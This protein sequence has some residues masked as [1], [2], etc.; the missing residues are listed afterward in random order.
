MNSPSL[1]ACVEFPKWKGNNQS[2]P[3]SISFSHLH[4][5]IN[6]ADNSNPTP[7]ADMR[8][9]DTTTMTSDSLSP[10]TCTVSDNGKDYRFHFDDS[11]SFEA[12]SSYF[13]KSKQLY[14]EYLFNI[15]N[16][17]MD[18][19]ED[20][21][22]DPLLNEVI[23]LL[24]CNQALDIDHVI[25]NIHWFFVNLSPKDKNRYA[26]YLSSLINYLNTH[27]S[28]TPEMVKSLTDLRSDLSTPV[29][30]MNP[31]SYADITR[32][33]SE[34]I[35]L[36]SCREGAIY[37][38]VDNLTKEEVAVKVYNISDNKLKSIKNEIRALCSLRDIPSIVHIF[39]AYCCNNMYYIVEELLQGM[40]LLDYVMK[41]GPLK[42]QEARTV[43]RVLLETIRE[44]HKRHI[45]HRDIKL[46]NVMF[47]TSENRLEDVVLLD[48]SFSIIAPS[49]LEESYVGTQEYASPEILKHTSYSVKTDMWSL[50]VLFYGLV[51]GFF[52]FGS[53]RDAMLTEKIMNGLFARNDSFNRLTTQC[54]DL[55]SHIL[56][57][58][59][60]KRYSAEEALNH[61]WFRSDEE[62]AVDIRS[63]KDLAIHDLQAITS[64]KNS[65]KMVTSTNAVYIILRETVV[66][67]TPEDN[68]PLFRVNSPLQVPVTSIY[69]NWERNEMW[70]QVQGSMYYNQRDRIEG[71]EFDGLD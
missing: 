9:S 41:N 70:V 32:Y 13:N 44:C 46:D 5:L 14:N 53:Q 52:P 2:I 24:Y 26:P 65:Y 58:D 16:V 28:V 33:F 18:Y 49:N 22:P 29:D 50:G 38:A 7:L 34:W 68:A 48:F 15:C 11:I 12:F 10:L 67:I 35:P 47:R 63:S 1:F 3:A 20:I 6:H 57:V 69:T 62:S 66:H 39:Q 36:I 23:P 31:F 17:L 51:T 60:M 42:E 8:V 45:L 27:S 30:D 64:S 21:V 25:C 43:M 71:S 40:T 55:I 54:Q 56:E 19:S 59:P 61:P 37:R 4:I